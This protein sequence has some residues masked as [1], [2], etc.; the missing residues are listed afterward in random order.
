M[1][2]YKVGNL[3]FPISIFNSTF[4]RN[5]IAALHVVCCT[6]P[7]KYVNFCLRNGVAVPRIFSF[8]SSFLHEL[9]PVGE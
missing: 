7:Y 3:R 2:L 6:L 9:I 4:M 8:F 5:V 1:Q